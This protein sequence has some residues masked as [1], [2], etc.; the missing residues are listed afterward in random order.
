VITGSIMVTP[1]Y[2][3][4]TYVFS[5]ASARKGLVIGAAFLA[6]GGLMTWACLA[7]VIG[8]L[9]LAGNLIVPIAWIAPSL[10]LYL[11]RN[12]FL[13][14]ELSQRWLV[15]LQLFRAIGG[16]F[17]IEMSRGRVPGIF[18]YP[19]GLGDLLV[20]AVAGVVL[21]AC[22]TRSEIPAPFLYGLIALGIADFLSALFFGFTSSKSPLQ[23]F[24]PDPPSQLIEFPTGM[25]PMFL[26]PYAIFF[27][28][29]SLLN[30][31]R[32][33]S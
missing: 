21:V 23:L 3:L 27:H 2:T 32:F 11:R 14:H 13:E 5:G 10:I 22:R 6:W 1:F 18:A 24:F 4:A 16:T 30:D 15:G 29:L 17:L 19:A 8:F 26:V 12:W 9:D 28:T 20:A 7:N 25:I 33:G 31:R